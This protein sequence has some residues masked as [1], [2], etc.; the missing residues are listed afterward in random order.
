MAATVTDP[1]VRSVPRVMDVREP[2][3]LERYPRWATTGAFLII[4]MAISAVLRTRYIS[5]QFWMDEA[6]T[7]GIAS[8][9]LSQIPGLLRHDGSPPLFYILLHLWIRVF[10]TSEAATH[11]LPLLF[12][13][14][15]I[16]VGM[17]AGWSLFG[18]RAGLMAATLFA[19]NAWLTL[20]AQETRMYELM[21]LLGLV[22]TVAFIHA[23]INRRRKYLVVFAL[24]EALMLY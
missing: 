5:G 6:I 16:P 1:P 11:A 18:R 12:G 10:G 4:L 2:S 20:Y 22:A 3:W 24:A 23:F 14:L 8:H 7:T 15:T 19:F 9:P 13:L 17:W 21:A